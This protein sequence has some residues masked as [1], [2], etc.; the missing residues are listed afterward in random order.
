MWWKALMIW[1][2]CMAAAILNGTLRELALNRFLGPAWGHVASTVLLAV[3]LLAIIGFT[4]PWI[5]PSTARQAMAIGGAWLLLTL[6]FEF[7]FGHWVAGKAWTVLL[8]DY[9][10]WKGRIWVAIPLIMALVPLWHGR[11]EGLFP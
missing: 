7:G 9:Q 6:S 10:V 11:R 3:I 5:G 4:L 1:F 8:Y 2:L